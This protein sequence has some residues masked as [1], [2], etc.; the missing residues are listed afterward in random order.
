MIVDVYV[1]ADDKYPH[2]RER[3][4]GYLIRMGEHKRFGAM[5]VDETYHMSNLVALV[6]ALDRFNKPARIMI[7]I[8]DYW[9][10]TMLVKNAET[11]QFNGW[12]NKKHEKVKNWQYWQRAYNKL[13]V[14]KLNGEKPQFEQLTPEE[15]QDVMWYIRLEKQKGE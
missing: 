9:V 6:E 11:W 14:L 4:A 8:Q 2:R 13:Q 5:L 12:Q 1:A 3:W 10:A 7:H 15:L